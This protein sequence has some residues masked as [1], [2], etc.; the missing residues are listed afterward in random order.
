M[1]GSSTSVKLAIIVGINEYP[2]DPLSFPVN[3]AKAMEALLSLPEYGFETRT[4]LDDH[5]TRSNIL[6]EFDAA[7]ENPPDTLLFYF[8]GHGYVTSWK[9][10]FLG[11]FGSVRADEGL[12]L[13]QLSQIMQEQPEPTRIAVAMIDCCHSGAAS[14]WDTARPVD[15]ASVDNAVRGYSETRAVIA[16]CRPEEEALSATSAPHG[17]FTFHL[18]EALSGNAA[19][20]RGEMVADNVVAY[21]KARMSLSSQY[22]V[23]RC[24]SAG[25]ALLGT[26]FQP[27]GNEP[28][29]SERSATIAADARGSL[30]K[31]QEQLQ[32]Y[33]ADWTYG[34]GDACRALRPV[35]RWFDST[36]KRYQEVKNNVNFNTEAARLQSRRSHLQN[37]EPGLQFDGRRV[38]ESLGAGGFGSVWLLEG[39]ESRSSKIAL[40][41]YNPNELGNQTMRAMFDRGYRAMEQLDHER[42]VKVRGKSVVPL[43]FYMDYIEGLN[44]RS[45]PPPSDDPS[46]SLRLLILAADT[47]IHAHDAGVIHRDIKPENLLVSLRPDG[48]WL[49]FLTDFD[50]AWFSTASKLAS[51]AMANLSYGAPEY[52]QAPLSEAAH[53]PTVDTFSFAQLAFYAMSGSDPA[54]FQPDANSNLLHRRLN[55]W[56]VGAA[57][58]AFINWYQKCSQANPRSRPGDFREVVDELSSIESMLSSAGSSLLGQEQV[59][60]EIAY[61]LVGLPG[62][63]WSSPPSSIR[64]LSGRT[65]ISVRIAGEQRSSKSTLYDLEVHF[66]HEQI[67]MSQETNVKARSSL[68]SRVDSA[69]RAF[70]GAKKRF[71][72]RGSYDVFVD[73]PGVAAHVDG[74]RF[75]TSAIRQVIHAIEGA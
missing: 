16:A 48:V 26:G 12:D 19:D 71:G 44:L 37:L 52:L 64:S 61:S 24:D 1:T 32:S 73:L 55:H 33:M 2:H 8:S 56:D 53:R 31:Y 41:V 18:L 58:A 4:F 40:K 35:V 23:Y 17:E 39:G 11:T 7:R 42:I 69:L 65:Q 34:Y 66:S 57:A 67:T 54:A 45:M 75:A 14:A 13:Q 47:L 10:A 9:R 38:L 5:A 27:V 74:V 50:L 60:S 72:K 20:Y 62:A 51:Q 49:P 36:S 28:L 15:P 68:N 22:L 25:A 30:E 43:G 3:D 6:A 21:V 63:E 46:T 70:S 59:I 29:T